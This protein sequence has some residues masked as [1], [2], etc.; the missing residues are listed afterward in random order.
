MDLDKAFVA[1]VLK[2]GPD[3]FLKARAAV[4]VE[5]LAGDGRLAWETLCLHVDKYKDIPSLP[6]LYG[7]TGVELEDPL[8]PV[9]DPTPFFIDAILARRLDR[10]LSEGI[11]EASIFL[12][13]NQP[14]KGLESLETLVS[15]CRNQ[16]YGSSNVTPLTSRIDA[17][18]KHY[19]QMKA[20][21]RGILTPWET[22]NDITLGF[23]PEDL[24]LFVARSGVGK[25]WASIFLAM[26][27]W[28]VEKKRVLYV[29]TEMSQDRIALRC[30]S[31][32]LKLPFGEI[33]AGKLSTFAEQKLY[34]AFPAMSQETGFFMI[35]GQFDF[36]VETLA[37]A[38]DE[39]KPDLMVID[40]IYLLKTPGAN[41]TEQAANAF[42]DVKRLNKNK[43]IPIIVTSQF[44]RE[45][46]TNQTKTVAAESIALTDVAVW[47]SDLIF[48]LVQDDN[49][50]LDKRILIKPLKVRDGVG[51]DVEVR[52]DF[53]TMTFTELPK[54]P[55][56][57]STA[58]VSDAAAMEA[59]FNE[60]TVGSPKADD[61]VP[62]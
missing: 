48:G 29:T 22:V 46:K 50:K 34:S 39:S 24:C 33:R 25:T 11:K 35:G 15:S 23:W 18:I 47:N 27:A 2:G 1:S 17:V 3:T 62:F 61:G 38:I 52:W 30:F 13:S 9:T 28:Q 60:T 44:N 14:N 57:A 59:V 36:R 37:A 26:Y 8:S 41:R 42:N 5:L 19:E 54:G 31:Y 4:P 49:M 12:K 32:H 58:T 45:V 10:Q 16:G 55:G 6:A 21:V 7:T 56:S 43:K 40:G 53:D 51:T 20:G